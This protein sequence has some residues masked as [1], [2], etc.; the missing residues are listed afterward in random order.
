M[1]S[2]PPTTHRHFLN[3]WVALLLAC[4]VVEALIKQ[5]LE[6][7][8]SIRGRLALEEGSFGSFELEGVGEGGSDTRERGR[9]S[10]EGEDCATR[11]GLA[12]EARGARST[13]N[14]PAELRARRAM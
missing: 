9:W 8:E 13:S 10:G 2:S 6:S 12:M 3:P 4:S 14:E 7:I 11:A 5:I 1:T